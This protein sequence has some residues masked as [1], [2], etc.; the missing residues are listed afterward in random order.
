MLDSN[1]LL[2]NLLKHACSNESSVSRNLSLD[3]IIWI[4]SIRMARYRSPKYENR[5]P[6]KKH[7]TNDTIDVGTQQVECIKILEK[8]LCELIRNCI[9]FGNRTTAH[10]C[11]KLIITAS[12]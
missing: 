9:V 10:K 1:I 11:V 6:E 12:E 3:I 5:K 2:E 4:I 7:K 8:S